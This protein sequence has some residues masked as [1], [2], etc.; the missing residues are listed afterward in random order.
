MSHEV[1]RVRGAYLPYTKRRTDW[2]AILEELST[3]S[4][5]RIV[6]DVATAWGI[7]YETVRGRWKKYQ[8]G[9]A[10]KDA[11]LV[12]IARGD[13]DGRRDN[14]ASS[15]VRRRPNSAYVSIRRTSTPT[16]LSFSGW[17]STSTAIT[18]PPSPL[19]LTHVVTPMQI[20]HFVHQM[21]LWSASIKETPKY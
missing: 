16:S 20:S 1:P 7:P 14:L 5:P 15:L 6:K 13:V 10:K 8:Q 4:P 19:L 18:T 9:V 3:A 12:A 2:P 11:T 17:L 21:A